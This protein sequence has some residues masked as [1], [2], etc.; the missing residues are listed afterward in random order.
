[1]ATPLQETLLAPSTRPHVV[2]DLVKVVE[3]EVASKKGLSG[4]AVQAAY[5]AVTRVND[6]FVRRSVNRM[7]PGFAEALDPF[8][9]QHAASPQGSFGDYLA[10]REDDASEALLS[11]TDRTAGGSNNKVATKAYKGLRPMA[12][13]QVKAALPRLGSAIEVHA[14]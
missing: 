12:A 4:K 5:N 9:Q 2:D 3:L 14:G 6:D 7:L 10:S 13:K 11:V 1:M 8:W